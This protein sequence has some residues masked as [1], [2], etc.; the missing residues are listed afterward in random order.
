M[1]LLG[2]LVLS[3]SIGLLIYKRP[4][5]TKSFN[6]FRGNLP[7][8]MENGFILCV[9]NNWTCK[10]LDVWKM[11]INLSFLENNGVFSYLVVR[12]IRLMQTDISIAI[13]VSVLI[14]HSAHGK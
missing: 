1:Q 5:A 9:D 11:N 3:P 2:A 12:L 4:I 7:Q 6:V 13:T 14:K 10:Y 8:K